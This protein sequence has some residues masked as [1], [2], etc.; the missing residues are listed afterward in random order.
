[1]A[2]ELWDAEYAN[3]LAEFSNEDAAL[4][5]VRGEVEARG[6]DGVTHLALAYEDEDGETYPIAAGAA[7]AERALRP[8]AMR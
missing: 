6:S 5:A 4:A 7:L 2:Y 1:M 8:I 3:L